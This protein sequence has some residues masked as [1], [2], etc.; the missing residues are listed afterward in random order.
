M[1]ALRLA[2]VGAFLGAGLAFFVEEA[3]FGL[4]LVTAGLDSSSGSEAD[5]AS[6]SI[7]FWDIS[8]HTIRLEY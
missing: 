5:E 6:M 4:G 8:H 1:T 2:G 7:G 3:G